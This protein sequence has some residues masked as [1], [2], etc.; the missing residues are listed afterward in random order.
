MFAMVSSL[1]L[2]GFGTSVASCR[3][4]YQP[5][6]YSIACAGSCK[7]ASLKAFASSRNLVM[8][9]TIRVSGLSATAASVE[10]TQEEIYWAQLVTRQP[11]GLG[12][13]LL[14]NWT[15]PDGILIALALA[16]PDFVIAR[17]MASIFLK[18]RVA[19]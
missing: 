9:R 7:P 19:G 3:V 13:M 18:D 2:G 1:I 16:S 6:G 17:L 5:P 8:I 14:G 15:W 10:R 12:R 4:Q 11:P